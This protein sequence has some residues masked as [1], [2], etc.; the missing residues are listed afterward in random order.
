MIVKAK[1]Y[2]E[3]KVLQDEFNNFIV[4]G[5]KYSNGSLK[6]CFAM[7]YPDGTGSIGYD[8]AVNY[9]IIDPRLSKYWDIEL[10]DTNSYIVRHRKWILWEK[11]NKGKSLDERIDTCSEQALYKFFSDSIN[12]MNEESNVHLIKTEKLG[13]LL[14]GKYRRYFIKIYDDSKIS[15]GY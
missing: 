13:R 12:Q 1:R 14:K 7:V 8:E 11:N 3:K 9:E 15:G 10:I 5:L 6:Y 2:S 4:H